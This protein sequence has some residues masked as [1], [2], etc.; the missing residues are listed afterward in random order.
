MDFGAF[1]AGGPACQLFRMEDRDTGKLQ[2]YSLG[3]K[4]DGNRPRYGFVRDS[5]WGV[6]IALGAFADFVKQFGICDASPWPVPYVR[7]SGTLLLPARVSLPVVLERA[8][9][10][11]SGSA[12]ELMDLEKR[13][14]PASP[15]VA[16]VRT[17]DR[18]AVACTSM[19]YD[20]MADGRWLAYKYVPEKIANVVA[21]KLGGIIADA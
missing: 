7:Q 13:T 4:Q 14:D 21:G 18:A 16:L 9:V 17:A 1:H 20:D 2:V 6:W 11:C 8:L 5:R 10:L 15:Y 3:I 12:P 19:V